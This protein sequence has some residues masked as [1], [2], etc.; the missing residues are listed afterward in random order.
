MNLASSSLRTRASSH[1]SPAGRVLPDPASQ[2]RLIASLTSQPQ[3]RR[4]RLSDL[5][6][7]APSVCFIDCVSFL[8]R[9]L[10]P[11]QPTV[12]RGQRTRALGA[13]PPW[14]LL[15]SHSPAASAFL[16]MSASLWRLYFSPPACSL[17]AN[18]AHLP[19]EHPSPAL[20][21]QELV[22][23]TLSGVADDVLPRPVTGL[24]LVSSGPLN[25]PG[26]LACLPPPSPLIQP[27]PRKYSFCDNA[28]ACIFSAC[29]PSTCVV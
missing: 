16:G 1:P 20:T 6:N 11:P 12:S 23:G 13:S 24:S 7:S 19:Q 26:I 3:T 4:G 21:P 15:C 10:T 25:I 27:Q 8:D 17:L 9:R 29:P 14:R 22:R 18:S 28:A 2:V 5:R